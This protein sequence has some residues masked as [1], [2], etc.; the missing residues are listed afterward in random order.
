MDA[1][2][3]CLSLRASFFKKSPL[4]TTGPTFLFLPILIPPLK[5]KTRFVAPLRSAIEPLV[6]PPKTVQ[7]ARIGRIRMIYHAVLEHER[8]HA[9]PLPD[10][11]SGVSPTSTRNVGHGPAVV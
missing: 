4:S 5:P 1:T 8:A 3:N 9:R 6:H 7:S 10:E 2:T 11:C